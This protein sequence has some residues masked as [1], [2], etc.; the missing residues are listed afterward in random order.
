MTEDN[1]ICSL[2]TA[3]FGHHFMTLSSW[4]AA[5]VD[6]TL[7]FVSLKFSFLDQVLAFV[8]EFTLLREKQSR[9]YNTVS[10]GT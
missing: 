7:C 5:L 2:T 9:L 8:T 4:W 6:N 1:Y 3:E 10:Q